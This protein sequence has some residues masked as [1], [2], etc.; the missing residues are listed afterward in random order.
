MLSDAI[1][2]WRFSPVSAIHGEVRKVSAIPGDIGHPMLYT[3]R[4]LVG[5]MQWPEMWANCAVP[6]GVGQPMYTERI[7]GSHSML[8]LEVG[9]RQPR[10]CGP[11]KA[12]PGGGGQPTQ[13]STYMETLASPRNTR[14]IDEPVQIPG[15]IG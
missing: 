8:N 7:G 2:T 4:E 12:L 13:Y 5:S 10:A 3:Y 1:H 15:R 6:G 11:V 9:A 14:G